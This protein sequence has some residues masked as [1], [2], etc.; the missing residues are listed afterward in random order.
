LSASTWQERIADGEAARLEQLAEQLHAIQK[1]RALD[2][3]AARAL[4][5]KGLAGAEAELT[6]LPDIDPRARAG[7]FS[8]P[9][10]Y[11]AYVRFSNGSGLRQHDKKGDV[12]GLAIK[13]LGVE[14][15]KLIPVP[16]LENARTQD[17]LLIQSPS[18][19]F[20]DAEEFIW[21]V[22]AMESPALLLPK[23]LVRFGPGGGL[24]LLKRLAASVSRPVPSMATARYFSAVPVR[25]GDHAVH[26][27]VTP[28][29]SAPPGARTPDAQDG[30]TDE[31]ASRLNAGP[32]TFDFQLQFF[33]DEATTPIEDSSVEWKE[34]DAPFV[35]VARLTLPKQDL[36]A[37]RGL[38]LAAFVESL[39]FDPWHAPVEFR[40]LGNM[41]R[42]RNAAYRLSTQERGVAP[43]PDGSERFD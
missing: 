12:R 38:K 34:A 26:Y 16:A 17:F 21:F 22:R 13:L 8:Q 23:V 10:T 24:R 39:S 14:G 36:R 5:A 42:A 1:K 2:G 35:T 25:W 32:V 41:M 40:P 3:K 20:R 4:H 33:K 30:L 43:E 6:V 27:A 15:K 7:L 31:L 11:R 18:T 19:P 9:G 28:H 29:A 37:P